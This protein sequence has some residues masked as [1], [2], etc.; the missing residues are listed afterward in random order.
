MKNS[1]ED[2]LQVFLVACNKLNQQCEIEHTQLAEEEE[3]N[4]YIE[5][6]D[7]LDNPELSIQDHLIRDM[8]MDSDVELEESFKVILEGDVHGEEEKDSLEDEE[9]HKPINMSPSMLLSF[10]PSIDPFWPSQSFYYILF[11]LK[12]KL[13]LFPQARYKKSNPIG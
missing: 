9:S 4:L 12:P 7:A 5:P 2:T 10:V 1:L 11:S 6:V 13:K 3:A 8:V